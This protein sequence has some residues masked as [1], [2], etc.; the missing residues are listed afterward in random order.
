[1]RL[2]FVAVAMAALAAAGCAARP[3]EPKPE[4]QVHTEW[5]TCSACYFD[6]VQLHQDFDRI[7]AEL[8]EEPDFKDP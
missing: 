2:A 8:D 3:P 4:T 6:R 7:F 5:H 1:M